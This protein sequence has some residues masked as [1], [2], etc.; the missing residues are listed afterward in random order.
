MS[1]AQ[2]R[3]QQ[4]DILKIQRAQGATLAPANT[5]TPTIRVWFHVIRTGLLQS[6][7]NVPDSWLVQQLS[8]LNAAFAG[9]YIFQLA[10]TTRTTNS[11][12]FTMTP[13]SRAETDATN[14]LRVGGMSTLNFYTA[15]L[16]GG[17]LG[18]AYFPTCELQPVGC[19]GACR[20]GMSLI[21]I[22]AS[23]LRMR[24]QL[25]ATLA[26][27]A[28]GCHISFAGFL[29]A[30]QPVRHAVHAAGHKLC[31]ESTSRKLS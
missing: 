30:G 17:A 12:W 31:H 6:Q 16:T 13:G 29:L 21:C 24:S 1:R 27:G 7:G 14:T 9:R 26:Q 3:A 28:D 22:N 11:T 25:F 18:W 23:I 2:Q 10:G 15:G 19:L 5:G 20:S 4:R 8:V